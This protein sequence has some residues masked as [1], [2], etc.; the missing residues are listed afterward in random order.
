M[1]LRPTLATQF[2]QGTETDIRRDQAVKDLRRMFT[3][4][5]NPPKGAVAS[6][7]KNM[8]SVYDSY[9]AAAAQVTDRSQSSQ[10]RLDAMKEGTKLQLQQLAGS[11]PN[12]QSAYNVLFAQLIGE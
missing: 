8:L 11:N 10:R 3:E 7:L 5:P 2:A 9:T 1:A 4:E 12:T 6:V